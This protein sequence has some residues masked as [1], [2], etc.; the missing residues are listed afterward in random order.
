MSRA[1]ASDN[2]RLPG[3]PPLPTGPVAAASSTSAPL[4]RQPSPTPPAAPSKPEA[5]PKLSD[6]GKLRVGGM[7]EEYISLRKLEDAEQD[8]KVQPALP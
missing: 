6:K 3:P 4:N 7:L 1:P 5:E 2:Q 8:F